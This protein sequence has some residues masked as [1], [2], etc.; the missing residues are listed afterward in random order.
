EGRPSRPHHPRARRGRVEAGCR[1]R[2]HADRPLHLYAAD[3]RGG[4]GPMTMA[5]IGERTVV[6]VLE[7]GAVRW[8]QRVALEEG[9]R[10][11]SYAELRDE[12]AALAGGL[13]DLGVEAGDHLALM[14]GNTIEHVL[15]WF[16]ANFLGAAEVP[17]NTGLRGSQ[18]QY[19][20]EH[21][22]ANVLVIDADLTDVLAD[23]DLERTSI[24]TVVVVGEESRIP[25][26]VDVRD[27]DS[28]RDHRP[29]APVASG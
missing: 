12:V 13:R 15:T 2:G 28:V 11:L 26:P 5:P 24:R 22:E 10:R 21:S 27:F 7:R 4:A 29:V 9:E 3:P 16:A 18:V 6:H 17:I 25:L 20:L 1:P 19:I 8:P 23:V 14:L